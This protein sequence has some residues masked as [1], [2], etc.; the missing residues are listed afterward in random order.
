MDAEVNRWKA[1]NSKLELAITAPRLLS[2]R[3]CI[4]V[5]PG[6]L[7]TNRTCHVEAEIYIG[8]YDPV[9]KLDDQAFIDGFDPIVDIIP[10]KQV[11]RKLVIRSYDKDFTFL[12][13]GPSIPTYSLEIEYMADK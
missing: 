5:V 9:I 10:S 1:P 7:T 12:L 11:P 6:K 4:L 3:D 13:K 8:Q 2:L